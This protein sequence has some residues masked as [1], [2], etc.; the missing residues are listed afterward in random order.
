MDIDIA[1]ADFAGE[2]DPRVIRA[3]LRFGVALSDDKVRELATKLLRT[4]GLDELMLGLE[5]AAASNIEPIRV[6]AANRAM[7][8]IRNMDNAVAVL[9]SRRLAAV[10]GVAPTPES[11][12]QWNAWLNNQRQPIKLVPPAT[13]A[14]FSGGGLNAPMPLVATMDDETFT[15]LLDY[16]DFLRQRDLDLVIVMDAT[17]SMI[18][19]VNQA[20]AGVDGLIHFL[21]DISREMRLAFVAYRDQDNPPIWD[22]H[23]FTTDITS[24]RNYLFDLRITGGRDYP[25][26]VLEGLTACGE[27][28][29]NPKSTRQIVLVGDAP[30]HDEDVYRVRALLDSYR[31]A[32]ITL[33]A[34]HVPMEYPPG[35]YEGL[36]PG[37]AA[38]S[39]QWLEDYNQTTGALFAELAQTGGGRKT[40]LR[41]ADELV[42]SIMHFTLEEAWWPVFDEFYA[43]YV[44]LCR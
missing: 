1:A 21:N 34:V 22:G 12:Q 6:E 24:I 42:P 26:A 27:L 39:R 29:W 30:P 28:K 25:E 13:S 43:M 7:R 32:G 17:A 23:P 11:A 38:E 18:P 16:L 9:I 31:D 15:R 8:L 14:T 10:L 33:H 3:A 35:H 20:R 44:G 36:S 37:K 2:T 19:M 5:I 40:Q 41:Q 4:R